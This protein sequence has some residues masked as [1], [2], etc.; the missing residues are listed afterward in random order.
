[1]VFIVFV[2]TLAGCAKLQELQPLYPATFPIEKTSVIRPALEEERTY[3]PNRWARAFAR[4]A[5][6][7]DLYMIASVDGKTKTVKLNKYYGARV[8]PGKY[9]VGVKCNVGGFMLTFNVE[10]EALAGLQHLIECTGSIAARAKVKQWIK[11][12]E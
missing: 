12:S 11:K 8:E 7:A 4:P 5:A 2:L 6:I 1:M 3:K 10:V 9:F